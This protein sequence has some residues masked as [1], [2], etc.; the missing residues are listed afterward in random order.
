MESGPSI[1]GDPFGDLGPSTGASL[2]TP[3]GHVYRV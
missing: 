3:R 2:V 1:L